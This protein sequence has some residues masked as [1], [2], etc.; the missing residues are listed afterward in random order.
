MIFGGGT[1]GKLLGHEG[2]ALMNEVSALI[3]EITESSLAP[4]VT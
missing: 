4:S 2:R 1:F 3:E